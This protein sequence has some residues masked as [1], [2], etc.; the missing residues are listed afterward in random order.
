[1]KQQIYVKLN[2]MEGGLVAKGHEDTLEYNKKNVLY[3]DCLVDY[4]GI[5][6]FPNSLNG[7]LKINGAFCTLYF[8]KVVLKIKFVV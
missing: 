1:M 6:I 5:Y 7:T 3:F 4:P 8:N 2:G